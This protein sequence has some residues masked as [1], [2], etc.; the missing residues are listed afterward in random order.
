M[1]RGTF[2]PGETGLAMRGSVQEQSVC[3]AQ[4]AEVQG[5]L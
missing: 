4:V 5:D 1:A 3:P 2:T